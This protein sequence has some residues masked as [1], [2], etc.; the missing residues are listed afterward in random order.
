MPSGFLNPKCK[1]CG[2]T[3]RQSRRENEKWVCHSCNI[4]FKVS[5]VV[6][7]TGKQPTLREKANEKILFEDN[8][9]NTKE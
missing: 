6:W 4:I 9:Q 7:I 2:D 5:N 3:L 8:L 1:K